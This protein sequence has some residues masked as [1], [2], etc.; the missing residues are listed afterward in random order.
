MTLTIKFLSGTILEVSETARA[1][2][3][4]EKAAENFEYYGV[5]KAELYEGGM[6]LEETKFSPYGSDYELEHE[7][8]FNELELNEELSLRELLNSNKSEDPF[9]DYL[10]FLNWRNA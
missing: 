3:L 6:L 7:F 4:Y 8:E 2:L 1:V 10:T 5:V 9:Q